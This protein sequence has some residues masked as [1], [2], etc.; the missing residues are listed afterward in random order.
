MSVTPPRPRLEIQVNEEEEEAGWLSTAMEYL[1]EGTET[2][3]NFTA[4]TIRDSV[5][6][7]VELVS[8]TLAETEFYKNN[9][10]FPVS[11]VHE[12]RSPRSSSFASAVSVDEDLLN[13]IDTVPIAARV[14]SCGKGNS[15]GVVR[16]DLLRTKNLFVDGQVSAGTTRPYFV[17][18]LG[19]F[20]TWTSDVETKETRPGAF[21]VQ[22]HIDLV[23][24]DINTD[25]I[26]QVF[27]RNVLLEDHCIGQVIVPLSSLVP[28]LMSEL[29]KT[30]S[31]FRDYDHDG[32]KEDNLPTSAV[33]YEIF[34]ALRPGQRKYRPA[35]R[36]ISQTGLWKAKLGFMQLH[37]TLELHS[38][39]SMWAGY[40]KEPVEK[41]IDAP[42]P[43]VP[44]GDVMAVR[45]VTES[46]RGFKRNFQRVKTAFARLFSRGKHGWPLFRFLRQ[47][48]SFQSLRVS[49]AVWLWVTFACLM[50][51]AFLFPVNLFAVLLV[52][53]LCGGSGLDSDE[54]YLVWNQ[55]IHDPDDDLGPFQK[56]AKVVF[57]L[58]K[59]E[60]WM[61]I[62]ADAMERM[63][64]V[65]SFADERVTV[66]ALLVCGVVSV[67]L[68][69][70]LYLVSFGT[71]CYAVFLAW[72]LKPNSQAT[73]K[74][75][76]K[77]T[78]KKRP[79]PRDDSSVATE[80]DGEDGEEMAESESRLAKIQH[81][82]GVV[83]SAPTLARNVFA[84][85]PTQDEL[86]HRWIA[87]LQR[88]EKEPADELVPG[89]GGEDEIWFRE[90]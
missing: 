36:D 62:T 5:N 71:V 9:L 41:L 14:Q 57:L 63:S 11:P 51:P 21:S 52:G 81:R 33:W 13:E 90:M 54:T 77:T 59:F 64:H 34:P 74:R 60:R 37:V 38:E 88:C 76:R 24:H 86:G 39:I 40:A 1:V 45:A 2:T 25:L 18:R 89:G 58:A 12:R 68:S 7:T 27:Q 79:V 42:Q 82:I 73:K 4:S 30:K 47:V 61:G 66:A 6:D 53:T 55:D 80:E 46:G 8:T 49:F 70:L 19:P 17:I 50:A 16:V 28:S 84:R 56:L 23:A 78:R 29:H 15:I 43:P 85:V 22:R 32:G 65:F 72:L 48:K 35:S 3:I 44:T 75:K 83:L 10:A 31:R 87:N 20:Q 67:A 26:V 69:L